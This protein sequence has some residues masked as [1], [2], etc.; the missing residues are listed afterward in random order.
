MPTKP[1]LEV[2]SGLRSETAIGGGWTSGANRGLCP[3]HFISAGVNKDQ[4]SSESMEITPSTPRSTGT[5]GPGRQCLLTSMSFFLS[6]PGPNSQH[7]DSAGLCVPAPSHHAPYLH[8]LLL[9]PPLLLQQAALL[10]GQDLNEA[11]AH[12][13]PPHSPPQGWIHNFQCWCLNQDSQGRAMVP[14]TAS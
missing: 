12:Q 10:L 9:L 5:V 8:C 14:F 4:S 1:P 7:S 3:A 13:S 6:Q 2:P 11:F